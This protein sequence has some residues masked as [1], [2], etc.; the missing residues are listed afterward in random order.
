MAQLFENFRL[1]L[2]THRRAHTAGPFNARKQTHTYTESTTFI[3]SIV[4]HNFIYDTR[5]SNKTPYTHT[6]AET[7]VP[8]F[9]QRVRNVSVYYKCLSFQICMAY[10]HINTII[11]LIDCYVLRPHF[12]F[13]VFRLFPTTP[14][15]SSSLFRSNANVLIVQQNS[16]MAHRR[17]LRSLHVCAPLASLHVRWLP[18][19]IPTEFIH[20]FY[21]YSKML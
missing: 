10:I 17:W 9:W 12:L 19:R 11:Y 3:S 20:T 21:F 13:V 14:S 18:H 1:L 5:N 4:V 6:H 15:S 7:W 16:R 8:N 2:W